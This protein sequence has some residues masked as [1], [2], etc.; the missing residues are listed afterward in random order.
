MTETDKPFFLYFAPTLTHSIS[1]QH[2][3][4]VLEQYD[5]NQ[6][7]KG[8]L[9]GDEQPTDTTMMS[10]E[11]IWHAAQTQTDNPMMAAPIM[12]MDDAF[13]A[14]MGFVEERGLE[15]NTLVVLMGDHGIYAKGTMYEMGSRI[16]MM[17]RYP[18]L[19]G[20]DNVVM[21]TDFV[22]SAMDVSAT[23]FDLVDK[24]LPSG[25][26]MDGVS[27]LDG[28]LEQIAM[29]ELEDTDS[30]LNPTS[31]NHSC[32][33][34]RFIDIL[35]S[36]SIVTDRY[37]YIWRA[38]DEVEDENGEDLLYPHSHDLEQLYDLKADP[39][40]KI[41]LIQNAS[42]SS[43]I[44]EFEGMM[45][46]YIEDICPSPKKACLM[47][48][49]RCWSDDECDGDVGEICHD[50]ECGVHTVCTSDDDCAS[51]EYC[52]VRVCTLAVECA[53]DADCSGT[54]ECVSNECLKPCVEHEDCNKN[55]V[56]NGNGYCDFPST[57]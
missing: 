3:Q 49:I 19:F 16:L 5:P 39:N 14:L 36:H 35:H 47:P 51:Y 7:P 32:C 34:H 28:V 29:N 46:E 11:A 15:Q 42:F 13:G 1:D 41:N 10:R 50:G 40:E 9:I 8:V 12:W 33:Q 25:Y 44:H 21:P 55:R 45:R 57:P 18:A 6:T 53:S 56:C 26:V 30:D 54:K 20:G 24:N 4:D 17:M 22:V 43:Q 23:I 31:L 38:A 2:I 27:I 37:Q 52:D 48:A